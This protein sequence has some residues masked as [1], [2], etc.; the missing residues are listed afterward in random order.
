MCEFQD[1]DS[2]KRIGSAKVCSG[3]YLL[4]VGESPRRQTHNAVHVE[5]KSQSNKSSVSFE[6][7]NKDSAIMLWHYRLGHPN[8]IYLK[9]LFPSLFVNKNLELFQCEVCQ[10]SKHVRNSYHIQPYKA[11][12][13]FSMIHNDVWGPSRIQNVTGTRWFI[14]ICR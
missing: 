9:K 11:S 10:M 3:V 7:S 4:K 13:P 8:F 14:F 6:N 2:G 1:L 5:S 12:H